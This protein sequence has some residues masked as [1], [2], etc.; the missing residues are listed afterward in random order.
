MPARVVPDFAN[1][2]G[3]RAGRMRITEHE[4]WTF[5]VGAAVGSAI[6]YWIVTREKRIIS[7]VRSEIFMLASLHDLTDAQREQTSDLSP[8]QQELVSDKEILQYYEWARR[9]RRDTRYGRRKIKTSP[10]WIAAEAVICEKLLGL[11]SIRAEGVFRVAESKG[12]IKTHDDL[13]KVIREQL[14]K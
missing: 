2:T 9:R 7:G 10:I 11:P 8:K 6:T 12:R 3:P 5:L 14:T 4:I 13:Q 1:G